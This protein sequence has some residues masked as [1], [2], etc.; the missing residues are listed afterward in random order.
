MRPR[1]GEA[2]GHS[3]V[4]Y[5][6]LWSSMRPASSI[7]TL[8]PA[9]ASWNAAMPP[10]APLPT[11]IT[12]HCPVP[13]LIDAASLRDS[14]VTASRSRV[15]SAGMVTSL[16]LLPAMRAVLAVLGLAT[17]ELRQDLVAL[18]AKLLVDPDLRGVVA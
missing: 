15:G 6:A 14:S 4:R 7:S 3:I 13:G 2:Y 16:R 5:S 12:S 8:T 1:R 11:T 18:V 10:A 9:V 17:D